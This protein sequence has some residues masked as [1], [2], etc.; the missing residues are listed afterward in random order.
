MSGCLS[1]AELAR[2]HGM[3][4]LR[5]RRLLEPLVT[6]GYV[7]PLGGDLYAAT[8]AGVEADEAVRRLC[9][10]L[11]QWRALKEQQAREKVAA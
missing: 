6:A 5:M 1:L 9:E 11:E 4:P 2:R 8:R 3:S 10:L 7:E